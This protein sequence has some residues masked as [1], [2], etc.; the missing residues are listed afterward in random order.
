VMYPN[1]FTGITSHFGREVDRVTLARNVIC[2]GPS[3]AIYEADWRAL[4]VVEA[5]ENV[6]DELDTAD[7]TSERDHA[8][9]SPAPWGGWTRIAVL[10]G[11]SG[12]PMFDGGR[13]LVAGRP[14]SFTARA[15]GTAIVVRT[16]GA[17]VDVEIDV[18]G[19]KAELVYTAP[20]AGRFGRA[21][22]AIEAHPGER[23][24]I[25]PRAG[26]FYDFHVW[27]TR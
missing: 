22:A 6:A 16:E 15:G 18:A 5:P 11:E 25:T 19:R 9:A 24:T 10:V 21:R 1:W 13:T 26:P 27:I 4:D 17:R 3:K 20:E 7:V 12:Q 14:E 23:V 8:Y 2:G